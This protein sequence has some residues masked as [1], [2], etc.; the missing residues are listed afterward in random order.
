MIPLAQLIYANKNSLLK[1][2]STTVLDTTLM[3][4][5]SIG[6]SLTLSEHTLMKRP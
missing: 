4:D 6:L 1:R 5:F 2:N 3:R